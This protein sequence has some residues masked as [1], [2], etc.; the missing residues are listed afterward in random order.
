MVLQIKG[1]LFT[2]EGLATLSKH[3]LTVRE[4][5][6]LSRKEAASNAGVSVAWLQKLETGVGMTGTPTKEQLEKYFSYLG[7]TVDLQYNFSIKQ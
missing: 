1:D 7:I 6:G 4:F 2:A 5:K 3:L